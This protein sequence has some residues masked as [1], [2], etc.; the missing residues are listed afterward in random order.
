M[1]VELAF[2]EAKAD[3]TRYWIDL[4]NKPEWFASQV[5]PAGKVRLSARFFLALTLKKRARRA[6]TGP[7]FSVREPQ[8]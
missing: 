5:N 6:T 3:V 1:Q 4:K 2:Q 8:V 7:S